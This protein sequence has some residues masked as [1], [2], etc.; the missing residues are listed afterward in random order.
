VSIFFGWCWNSP[1]PV[2]DSLP[3]SRLVLK[4]HVSIILWW[5]LEQPYS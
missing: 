1:T 2:S 5:V 3:G 4:H